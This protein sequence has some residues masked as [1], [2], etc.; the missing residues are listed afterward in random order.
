MVAQVA[1]ISV[2]RSHIHIYNKPNTHTLHGKLTD[3]SAK[4]TQKNFNKTKATYF[5]INIFQM[6]VTFVI[7]PL[8]AM[9]DYI[10]SVEHVSHFSMELNNL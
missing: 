4:T 7:L 3:A 10:Q 1:N 8:H 2:F 6:S 9:G 5:I